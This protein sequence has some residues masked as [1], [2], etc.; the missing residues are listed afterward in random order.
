VEALAAGAQMTKAVV[1]VEEEATKNRAVAMSCCLVNVLFHN[2]VA[3]NNSING[4]CYGKHWR[5]QVEPYYTFA[6][7]AQ[8]AGYT[9]AFTE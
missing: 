2:G 8:Q 4:N 5:E 1:D 7:H 6:V 3:H 9:A